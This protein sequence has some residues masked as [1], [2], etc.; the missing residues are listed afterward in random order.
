ML[1]KTDRTI[2]DTKQQPTFQLTYMYNTINYLP[3]CR[4]C[5]FHQ[6]I[7]Q[8]CEIQVSVIFVI[9]A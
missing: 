2:T 9:S 8:L 1:T 6:Y 5:L 3:E 4:C 7:S